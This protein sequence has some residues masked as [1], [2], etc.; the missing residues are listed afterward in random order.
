MELFSRHPVSLFLAGVGTWVPETTAD[1][2]I[3]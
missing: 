1:K 2:K 3:K